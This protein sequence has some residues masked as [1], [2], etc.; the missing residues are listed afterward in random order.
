MN[1]IKLP[2]KD[3]DFMV[4]AVSRPGADK[5][6][7]RSLIQSDDSFRVSAA[8]DEKL[9]DR[10]MNQSGILREISPVLFFEVLMR[11][12]A[13]EMRALPYTLE[14][15]SSQKIP[16]FDGADA[17]ELMKNE[18]FIYYQVEMLASFVNAEESPTGRF[19]LDELIRRGPNA[20]GPE[21]FNIHRRIGDICLL[22][23]GIFPE[24]LMQDYYY[25]FTGL[26][27]P[28]LGEERKSMADYEFLGQE[29]YGLAARESRSGFLHLK[30]VLRLM[31]ENFYLAKKPLNFIS[32][33]YLSLACS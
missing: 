10:I 28:I 33:N 24:H 19:G 17:L 22:M 21:R 16:V 1:K 13:R 2:Q 4:D 11:R 27:P 23:L 14:R 12:A 26:Q 5:D 8:G 3:I 9:F 30:E 29:F 6:R 25:L 20:E 18:D 15:T 32:E 7:L 31:A